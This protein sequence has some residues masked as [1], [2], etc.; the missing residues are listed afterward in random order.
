MGRGSSIR[1]CNHRTLQHAS[2]LTSKPIAGL[3]CSNAQHQPVPALKSETSPESYGPPAPAGGTRPQGPHAAGCQRRPASRRCPGAPA[4]WASTTQQQ[5]QRESTAHSVSK[6]LLSFTQDTAQPLQGED[7]VD[8]H[9]APTCEGLPVCGW[10]LQGRRMGL[11]VWEAEAGLE[12]GERGSPTGSCSGCCCGTACA[13]C[14][15]AA[16]LRGLAA[17]AWWPAWGR[18]RR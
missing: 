13:C 5:A 8:T 1:A 16:W 3:Q 6:T 10:A 15:A 11:L 14:T 7:A 18:T 17:G 4:G 9:A 12:D 2:S